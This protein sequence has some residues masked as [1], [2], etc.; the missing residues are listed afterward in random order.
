[1]LCLF[2]SLLRADALMEAGSLY[3][4]GMY[5]EAATAYEPVAQ[6]DSLDP[7]VRAKAFQGLGNCALQL[8]DRDKAK[9]AYGQSLQL[10]PSNTVLKAY[11]ERTWPGA[12]AAT[13]EPSPAASL[14]ASPMAAPSATGTLSQPLDSVGPDTWYQAGLKSA[15]LPGWAQYS[16][17]DTTEGSA[18]GALAFAGWVF[19]AWSY[20]D[21]SEKIAKYNSYA[22]E[23]SAAQASG[24]NYDPYRPD[25][26]Y[27]QA[28]IAQLTNEIALGALI[29]V[30]TVSIWDAIRETPSVKRRWFSLQPRAKGLQ[31]A[32]TRNF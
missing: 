32:M 3:K 30:Y 13:P 19:Y 1:V 23:A 11:V 5:A 27:E 17:G 21:A 25:G 28:S 16:R 26:A 8:K 7:K 22:A 12:A 4:I 20:N 29:T 24:Q 10:D 6:D 15:I 9:E 18:M 14:E 31:I 2:S